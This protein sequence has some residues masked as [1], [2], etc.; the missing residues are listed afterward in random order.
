MPYIPWWQRLSPPT[1]AERFNLGGLAGRVGLKPGGIVEPGVTYYGKTWDVPP[2]KLVAFNKGQ[3]I[4]K[5][6]SIKKVINEALETDNINI[7][8]SGTRKTGG[9]LTMNQANILSKA[10]TDIKAFNEA[11]KFLK[12]EKKE[13]RSILNKREANIVDVKA[14]A[15]TKKALNLPDIK[16]QNKMHQI[17]MKGASSVDDLAKELKISKKKTLDIADKLYTNI[18]STRV[19]MGKGKYSTK[20][21]TPWLPKN[22]VAIDTLLK[23]LN[24]TKGLA[25]T[26][27]LNIGKLF[28]NAFGRATL[29]NGKKNPSHNSK[30]YTQV[31]AKLKEYNRI[32]NLLPKGITLNL[33]HPL[34]KLA[35][36]NMNVSADKL[37]RVTPISESLNKGLKLRF[38]TAYA[39]AL[40]SNDIKLQKA[41][42][43]LASQLGI[44]I[45]QVTG[46]GAIKYGVKDFRKLNMADTII[47]NLKQQNVI[48][49]NIKNLDPNLKKA[50]GMERYKFN[51]AKIPKK[52]I[53]KLS[54]KLA[55]QTAK[56]IPGKSPLLALMAANQMMFGRKFDELWGFPLTPAR[57]AEQIEELGTMITD[58][59]NYFDG[60]IASLKK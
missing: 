42:Q 6:D 36:N 52:D 26:Q 30:K 31:M 18:Y 14:K 7:L 60:G 23:N 22:D 39:N 29:P 4:K 19:E 8:K 20:K 9:K 12:I 2:S 35:L 13:L 16:L 58:K 10:S 47:K 50:A 11:A 3:K 25:D 53:T 59:F 54:K 57:D 34:S 1:F 46:S 33:D 40:K 32:K 56:R 17:V 37:V 21:I 49:E 45:G 51:L 55:L 15:A 38:D 27:T 5:Y 43:K 28:Y 24:N 44:N 48:A 41:V